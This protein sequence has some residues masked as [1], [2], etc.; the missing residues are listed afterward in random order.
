MS[1]YQFVVGRKNDNFTSLSQYK[2]GILQLNKLFDQFLEKDETQFI[3]PFNS[4]AIV[5]AI[6][7]KEKEPV[8]GFACL[9]IIQ[10][11]KHG[12]LDSAYVRPK[13]TN[14][15]LWSSMMDALIR[16]SDK[17]G[18]KELMALPAWGDE[19]LEKPLQKKGFEKQT[20]G[21]EMWRRR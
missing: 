15:G 1:K 17:M 4:A 7:N 6:N 9:S 12:E 5:I 2:E 8:R 20:D 14:Q 21:N 11:D 18:V 13:D 19:F 10:Q 16:E 3:D